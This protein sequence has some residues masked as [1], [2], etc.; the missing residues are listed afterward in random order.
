MGGGKY[1]GVK[2]VYN[3]RKGVFSIMIRVEVIEQKL[4]DRLK[5]IYAA[6]VD[7]DGMQNA[8]A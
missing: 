4:K 1:K 8:N 5:N 2:P 6:Q 3:V 7:L